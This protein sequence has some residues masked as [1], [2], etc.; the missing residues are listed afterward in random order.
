MLIPP[1][2]GEQ[3]LSMTSSTGTT[4]SPTPP[5]HRIAVAAAILLAIL[6]LGA[7]A[8][9]TWLLTRDSRVDLQPQYFVGVDGQSSIELLDGAVDVTA[10]TCGG[11]NGCESA[12]GT[13]EMVLMKFATQNDAALAARSIGA[14]AYR[15]D[16]LV[17]NFI[18]DAVTDLDRRN[19]TEVLDGAWQ[20]EVD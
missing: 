6:I 4:R 16:W 19:A 7:L 1:G 3:T 14:N 18:G 12:W 13:D 20:D 2:D 17:A 11:A 10:A 8:S 15:S 5:W 9:A